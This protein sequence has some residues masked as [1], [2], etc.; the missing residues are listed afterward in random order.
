MVAVHYPQNFPQSVGIA[1]I[2]IPIL[3]NLISLWE[4]SAR[5]P[6]GMPNGLAYSGF[7]RR[8]SL[9]LSLISLIP[10][11]TRPARANG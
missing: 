7:S 3:G 4:T 5:V 6:C 8:E 9:A 2:Y 11:T 1:K 10:E